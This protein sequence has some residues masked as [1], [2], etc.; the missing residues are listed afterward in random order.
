MPLLK[1][2]KD[3][4]YYS[5]F[6]VKWRRRREGKTDYYFRKRMICQDK[7]KYNSPKY[8]IVVRLSKRNIICQ[9]VNS[10]IEGDRVINAFYSNKLLSFGIPFGLTNFPS[11]Y[12]CGIFLSKKIL[13]R[14]NIDIK[15]S[16]INIPN[17]TKAFLDIGLARATAGH[18]VFACMK[19]VIDGGIYVPHS[20]KKYP[21]YTVEKGFDPIALKLRIKGEHIYDYMSNLKEED[22]IKFNKYFSSSIKLKI[23]PSG[24]KELHNSLVSNILKSD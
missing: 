6:Q 18:K 8:R 7:R 12:A 22:E 1:I 3:K 4:A 21:G 15:H 20:E 9:F 13:A 17:T 24:Y 11:A 19:G 14:K 2:L 23:S 16:Y 10:N 5:R